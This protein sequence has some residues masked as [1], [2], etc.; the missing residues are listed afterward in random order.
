MAL[1]LIYPKNHSPQAYYYNPKI[2][3]RRSAIHG[4][5]VFA[6]KN[7][8]KHEVLEEDHFIIIKGKWD[9]IPRQIQEY[10][11]G[12]TKHLPD[13]KS[14]AALVFGSGAIYNSSPKPNASWL[15][16]VKKGRFIYYATKDIKKGQEILID[17]GDE[18]WESRDVKHSTH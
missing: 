6:K 14:K 8:K 16:S 18:Y 2:E 5:G 15:T 1:K 17:Y 13:K 12:W 4:M 7:I 9:N 3:V 11:F 10:I